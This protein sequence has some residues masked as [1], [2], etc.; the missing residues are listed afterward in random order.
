MPRKSLSTKLDEA[1]KKVQELEVNLVQKGLD[2][3]SEIQSL[4]KK[5]E[6]VNTKKEADFNV[7]RESFKNEKQ[8][9]EKS[10]KDL[11]KAVEEKQGAINSLEL[12]RFAQAFATQEERFRDDAKKWFNYTCI[13]SL[14]VLVVTSGVIY[15]T[16]QNTSGFWYNRIGYYLIDIIL[17]TL[18]AFTLKQY[19]YYVKLSTDYGNRKT[20]AQSYFN[21]IDS[22]DDDDE[23]IKKLFIDKVST[24]LAAPAEV[25]EESNTL[26]EKILETLKE[27][28]VAI[29]NFKNSNN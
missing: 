27:L 14:I 13:M 25:A 1:N 21:I 17:I 29:K 3:E 20:L 24:I 8:Q 18:L 22:A 9:L 12:K 28:A 4:T 26:F 23:T 16:L 7:E 2:H 5:N 10:V 6:E 19:S 15:L 11:E